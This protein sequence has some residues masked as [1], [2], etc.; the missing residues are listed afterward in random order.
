MTGGWASSAFPGRGRGSID[1]T[2][3]TAAQDGQAVGPPRPWRSSWNGSSE[4][5]CAEQKVRIASRSHSPRNLTCHVN[6]GAISRKAGQDR[7]PPCPNLRQD[8]GILE[9]SIA[10]FPKVRRLG[11]PYTGSG[12]PMALGAPRGFPWSCDRGL[13]HVGRARSLYRGALWQGG[14]APVS[15]RMR[16]SGRSGTAKPCSPIRPSDLPGRCFQQD[17]QRCWHGS[18]RLRWL[19]GR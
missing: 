15:K 6:P 11:W 10:R 16:R 8:T 1:E 14:P 13:G 18:L 2:G 17:R 9:L 3:M 12:F 5:S 19:A 4:S 7:Q